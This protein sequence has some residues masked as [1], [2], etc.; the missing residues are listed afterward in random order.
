MRLGI[1]ARLFIAFLGIAALSL[2]SGLAGWWILRDV[3][4]AQSR[5]TVEALPAVAA[6]QATGD[7]TTRI[8]AAGQSLAASPDEATRARHAEEVN[9]LAADIRRDLADVALAKLDYPLLAQLSGNAETLIANLKEQN[10]LVTTRLQLLRAYDRRAET[11]LTAATNLVDLSETLV[12]NASSGAFAV[13]AGLYGLIDGE[14]TRSQAY[15]A[16]DRLIEQD[17]YLLDRMWELRLRASQ[18]ALL[19]TRLSRAV[20][21]D[22]VSVLS[23]EFAAHLRIVKRRVAGIDDPIRRAQAQEQLM[24]LRSAAGEMKVNSSLFEDRLRLIS[25]GEELDKVTARNR[26]LSNSLTDI[27]QTVVRN[28]RGFALAAS[29][30]ADR[31]VSA[32]LLALLATTAVAVLISGLIVWLYVERGVVRRL[33]ELADAMRRL[34]IGDLAVDVKQGGTHELKDL[35]EAVTAFRDVSRERSALEAERERTNEEL[36]RHR[37]ELRELVAERTA[38]LEHEVTNHAAAREAAERASRAKSDFLATMSHEIR[39][40]MTGMLGMLRLLKDGVPGSE[41]AHRVATASASGEALMGILNSILDYS[42]IESGKISVD[43]VIFRLDETLTGIVALMRP[44]AEEKG[45]SLQLAIAPGIAAWFEGDAGKIR[46]I[47]FNL[48]SNAIKFTPSGKI[49]VRAASL[50]SSQGMQRLAISVADTGM[51]I[52]EAKRQS[53]FESFTQTD[54][55]ITRR[56]GGTGLGLSISRGL[57]QA[58]G[59]TLEVE[60][61]PGQGSTFTLALDLDVAEP[62]AATAAAEGASSPGASHSILIVEDD[63]ATREVA[64]HF[65]R[66]MGHRCSVARDGYEALA[67]SQ[68]LRPDIVLMDIS[69]PG[70]DGMETARLI[71][72]ALAPS[73]VRFI[74]MSAHVFAQE[75]DTYLTSGMVSYVPKPL[76]PE[77][78]AGAIAQ[79]LGTPVS[80]PAI[81]EAAWQTDMAALGADQMRKILAI[82]AK[83]LPERLADLRAAL[84]AEDAGRLA[85]AAHAGFSSASAAGFSQLQT[86]FAGIEAAARQGDVAVCRKAIAGLGDLISETLAEAAARLAGREQPARSARAE[87]RR[88]SPLRVT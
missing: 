44:S 39:T 34:T 12:S 20:T 14:G 30:Q 61:G 47:L 21:R 84:V 28:A 6:A 74:A 49:T 54:S 8:L 43:P 58:L 46:Q 72:E 15:D 24:A 53:I 56:Y 38:Q 82:S 66:A 26:Q 29:A 83:A 23:K 62:P 81:D 32:G 1:G 71:R 86:V 31:A 11:T 16:L 13:V 37:E 35:A 19:T 73:T 41:Q 77:A 22:E 45:L 76:V 3:S 75:V 88:D 59:G 67:L 69:L 18:L 25:I 68:K 79:A 48:I 85:S 60:S 7:S 87:P 70:L 4:Q 36:R 2:S 63:D 42:K 33:Q 51:G 40:P 10:Q 57:A 17:I 9:A 64:V 50:P 65:I 78:L 52:P 5:I 55:S 80:M 27:A